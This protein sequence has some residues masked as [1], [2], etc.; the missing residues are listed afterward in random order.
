VTE[1]MTE[2]DQ[3]LAQLSE[4]LEAIETKR[5][6]TMQLY[7]KGKRSDRSLHKEQLD[8]IRDTQHAMKLQHANLVVESLNAMQSANGNSKTLAKE[9]QQA[10]DKLQKLRSQLVH[11]EWLEWTRSVWKFKD[12]ESRAKTGRHPAQYSGV[13]PHRVCKMYSFIGD[14]VLDP[15]MGMGTTLNEAWKLQRHS[16]GIDINPKYVEAT[17]ER[18]ANQFQDEPSL[19][20]DR[21]L[22]YQP[23]ALFGDARQMS[24]IEDGSIQLICTHPPYWNAI[25]I[26]EL[27]DD[28][29]NVDNDSYNTFLDEMRV[30]FREMNRVLEDDRL[31]C[32]VTGDVMRKVDGVTQLFPLHADYVQLARQTGFVPWD[33]FIWETKIRDS[34]GKPMMGSYPYPHK[35]FSQFA[36]NY[37]MLFRKVNSAEA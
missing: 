9:L 19:F 24:D 20:T 13:L 18:I 2:Y 8:A 1:L 26:S 7:L 12:T 22:E 35:I 28:L 37:V 36:H 6:A 33:I 31:C 25:R 10:V 4:Q 5:K 30:V 15:F 32:I 21:D 23:K 17:Q 27:E 3:Q 29:S 11:G 16:I 34:G 14:T